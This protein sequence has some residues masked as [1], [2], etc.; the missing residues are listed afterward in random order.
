LKS[1]TRRAAQIERAREELTPFKYV[2]AE[3]APPA[4]HARSSISGPERASIGHLEP[5]ESSERQNTF[6][7]GAYCNA[8]DRGMGL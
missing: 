8:R 5:S 4:W 6:E 7:K 1:F 3:R 2:F